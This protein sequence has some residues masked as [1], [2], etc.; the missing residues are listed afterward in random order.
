M[1]N[2]GRK[3]LKMCYGYN[4]MDWI[5]RQSSRKEQDEKE[6]CKNVSCKVIQNENESTKM[7]YAW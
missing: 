3:G 1:W 5:S 2:C 4:I 6:A 7:M